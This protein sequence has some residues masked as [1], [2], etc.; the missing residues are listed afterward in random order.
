MI[1]GDESGPIGGDASGQPVDPRTQDPGSSI[2]DD[3]SDA[4]H[5][6]PVAAATTA[7]RRR[8]GTI[9]KVAF[10]I[11]VFGFGIYFFASRWD[12][13]SLQL[14]RADWRWLAA[15]AVFAGIGLSASAFTLRSLLEMT[16]RH[17]LAP[18]AAA[19]LFFVSQLGKYL[20]GSVWPVVV[21]TQMGRKHGI[22]GDASATAGVLALF[23]SLVTGGA[24][25]IVVT[26]AG[27]VGS[28]AGG[29][30]WLLLLLP[31]VIVMA[32]PKVVFRGVNFGLKILRRKPIEF[33]GGSRNHYF[34]AIGFQVFSW[35]MLG[36][37]CWALCVSLGADPAT[38]LVGAI[39]GFALAFT[40]GTVFVPAPA[41]AGV[42]EAVLGV[43]LSSTL[44][45]SSS[46]NHASVLAVVLLSRA[47]LAVLDFAF[48]GASML[49]YRQS[50]S[51]RGI[52]RIDALP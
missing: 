3:A 44:A 38:S 27:S 49:V 20:P 9:L 14:S 22:D 2:S 8:W 42:R 26:L 43:A 17:R 24:L 46:F 33:D 7:R 13:I 28:G 30:W 18:A 51:R 11:A 15:A 47:V 16:S 41:G 12:E 25:G 4:G 35:L 6:A 39:G 5:A 23:L 50:I 52:D 36:L 10:G 40:A 31:V 21:V 37:Q 1:G 19:R 48:A 45:D 32:M 34:A 29:L